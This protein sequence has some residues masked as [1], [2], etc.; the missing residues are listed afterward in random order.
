MLPVGRYGPDGPGD[1]VYSHYLISVVSYCLEFAVA[2][3]Q[4]AQENAVDLIADSWYIPTLQTAP[5]YHSSR[6]LFALPRTAFRAV[7]YDNPSMTSAG[8]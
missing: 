8:P 1:P 2:S 7:A 6:L 3:E 5:L 4:I